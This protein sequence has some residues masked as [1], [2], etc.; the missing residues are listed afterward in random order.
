MNKV[1][2]II[3]AV[4]V[5]GVFGGIIWIGK[6]NNQ[7]SSFTGDAT[8][9]INAAP[10]GD[11]VLGPKTQK[12]TFI[13]YGDYECPG[14]GRM[15]QTVKD[16][17]SKYPDKLTFV[18]RNFPLTSIHANALAAA[19]AA[20]AAGLQGKYF[21]MHDMLYQNQDAWVTASVTDRTRIFQN[22]A[23]QLGLD[24]T[25][26][27]QDLSSKDITDKIN[28]DITTGKDT[29]KVD[30]TPSFVLDGKKVDTKTSVDSA[31]LT[32]MVDDAVA[33]AFPSQ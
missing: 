21:D 10:I 27:K 23:Q 8:H 16:L 3:F 22:Y 1:K 7:T 13:E 25:K 18:F 4:I 20:E 28:R 19:T 33:K 2:W 17:T 5:L 29:F 15:Y 32:K 6:S 26:Y 24:I 12:V 11:H 14:C 31:A 30:S 9:I